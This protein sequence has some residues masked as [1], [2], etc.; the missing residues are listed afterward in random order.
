MKKEAIKQERIQEIINDVKVPALAHI[1][2]LQVFLETSTSKLSSEDLDYVKLMLNS[3]NYLQRILS[4]YSWLQHIEAKKPIKLTYL[5]FDF[6][7]FLDDILNEFKIVMKFYNLKLEYRYRKQILINADTNKLRLALECIL[8]AVIENA[9]KNTQLQITITA[10]NNNLQFE[11]RNHSDYMEQSLVDC[12]FD[13]NKPIIN[14]PYHYRRLISYGFFVAK[15]IIHAHF[16]SM[17]I[18]SYEENVNIFGF[19]IPID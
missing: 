1:E 18:H 15:E 5:K 14:A 8:Y 4:I 10:R 16:G 7:E 17:I 6:V 11:I 2:A 19:N 12:L 9:Y 13:K 3:A